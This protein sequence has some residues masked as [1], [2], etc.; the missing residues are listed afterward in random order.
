MKTNPWPIDDQEDD[1]MFSV[2]SSTECT[3]LMYAS[4]VDQ[5]EVDSY[6]EIYDS[7]FAKDPQFHMKHA[8]SHERPDNSTFK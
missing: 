7:T 6:Q 8:Y 3:G 1:D 5:T 2:A 4:P